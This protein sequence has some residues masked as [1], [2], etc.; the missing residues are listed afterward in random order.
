MLS[1]PCLISEALWHD[2]RIALFLSSELDEGM[3]SASSPGK[4][5]QVS[6][7]PEAAWAPERTERCGDEKNLVP[8]ENQTPVVELTARS[9]TDRTTSSPEREKGSL[10]NGGRKGHFIVS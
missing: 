6:N 10:G 5:I 2:V 7:G 8:A 4:E 9:S 1:Y 3:W